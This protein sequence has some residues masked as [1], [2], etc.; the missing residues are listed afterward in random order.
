M[1][2]SPAGS[3]SQELVIDEEIDEESIAQSP[4]KSAETNLNFE[5]A[6]QSIKSAEGHFEPHFRNRSNSS[7]SEYFSCASSESSES[8]AA[9]LPSFDPKYRRKAYGKRYSCENCGK[10]YSF[11][12]VL[13]RH[14]EKSMQCKDYF[15]RQPNRTLVISK[16]NLTEPTALP[17]ISTQDLP[18]TS[19]TPV[20]RDGVR[21]YQC[22]FCP[23]VFKGRDNLKKHELRHTGARPYE[24]TLCGKAFRQSSNLTRHKLVHSEDRAHQC[25]VTECGRKFKTRDSLKM[26]L[27]IL[28]KMPAPPL[29]KKKN[30]TMKG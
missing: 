14:Q 8:P 18:P 2:D 22:A 4:A 13:R 17:S 20:V 26:H 7:E 9:S 24:C 10:S 16:Q 21:F 11:P 30:G 1:M 5:E 19:R 23:V 15:S 25:T 6:T 29:E 12:S 3:E 28:H 27:A